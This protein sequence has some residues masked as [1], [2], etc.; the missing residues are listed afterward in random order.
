MAKEDPRNGNDL[1]PEG[2]STWKKH[3]GQWSFKQYL[4]LLL[5]GGTGTGAGLNLDSIA[6][7]FNSKPKTAIT[8]SE[9][10]I[11]GLLTKDEKEKLLRAVD[12]MNQIFT[13]MDRADITPSDI[14]R[15]VNNPNLHIYDRKTG[16]QN[17]IV[18][19]HGKRLVELENLQT[20]E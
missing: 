9:E 14:I 19:E 20:P 5:L 13:K 16:K 11:Q 12:R 8:I 7:I 2:R 18:E 6:S 3:P 10:K 4:V 17:P 15:H 1:G